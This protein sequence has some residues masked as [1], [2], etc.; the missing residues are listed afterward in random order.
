M[1][2]VEK[3]ELTKELQKTNQIITFYKDE[4]DELES[5]YP[6]GIPDDLHYKQQDLILNYINKR[7]ELQSELDS[8]LNK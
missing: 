7:D 6:N 1:T 2:K 5:A 3:K 4:L 8:L